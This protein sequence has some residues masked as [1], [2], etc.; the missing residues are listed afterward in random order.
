MDAPVSGG[1]IG[2]REGKLVIMMGGE[3][4]AIEHCL[5]LLDCYAAECKNMGKAGAG[6]HTKMVNQIMVA[7]TVVGLCESLIYGH[8]AGL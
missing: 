6:Q 1:D 2:A 8:K 3:P 5:P 7:S 4:E